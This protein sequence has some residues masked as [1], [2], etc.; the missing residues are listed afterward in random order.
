MPSSDRAAKPPRAVVKLHAT[1][2]PSGAHRWIAC[3]GSVEAAMT[4]APKISGAAADE[5]TAAHVLLELC[6]LLG[7]RDANVFD[8]MHLHAGFKATEEM[9]TAVNGALDWVYGY[10]ATNPGT[11]LHLERR[12]PVGDAVGVPLD[13]LSGTADITL[14][15]AD[16]RR[17]VV[18][19]YKH[20]IGKVVE[21]E[22]NHQL[23]QYALG[24]MMEF[25]PAA[26]NEPMAEDNSF[27]E[28]R[29]VVIQPRAR[30][31][32]GPVREVTYTPNYLT[33]YAR[34]TL[35]PA[36]QLAL[37]PDAPRYA[38]DHCT[39]CAGAGGC[40]TLA[41][42]MFNTAAMEFRDA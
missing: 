39:W 20:G 23:L 24:A 35:A 4:S 38:G 32:E 27:E 13:V 3:P 1:L 41:R 15:D 12:L 28:Y 6:L 37:R 30:H 10:L 33:A 8:G 22:D 36:A 40:K 29:V 19:D 11:V 31:A 7:Y 21:V 17:I 5:G 9:A 18:A 16:N 14:V 2:S 26:G 42:A 34:D 25:E